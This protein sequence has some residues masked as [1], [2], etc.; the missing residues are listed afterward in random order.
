MCKTRQAK[1]NP[2]LI[3]VTITFISF[4]VS[5]V[6]V[7]E[8]FV[9][10]PLALSENV[11]TN[12]HI[13]THIDYS[14][15]SFWNNHLKDFLNYPGP[16]IIIN[17]FSNITG[18]SSYDLIY[19]PITA[20]LYIVMLLCFFKMFPMNFSYINS[21]LFSLASIYIISMWPHTW[22]L[23]YHSIGYL[24]HLLFL[25]LLIK[26]F[27]IN[28][29][30]KYITLL[31]LMHTTSLLSYY[32]TSIFNIIF[33]I[34]LASWALI[35]LR[36]KKIAGSML[37]FSALLFIMYVAYDYM[38]YN[39]IRYWRLEFASLLETLVSSVQR[40]LMGI[41]YSERLYAYGYPYERT[42]IDV[43]L[44]RIN[45]IFMTLFPITV[46]LI[47]FFVKETKIQ[48]LNR[49][50][51]CSLVFASLTL[52]AFESVPY[53]IFTGGLSFRYLSLFTPIITISLASFNF[54]NAHISGK[55]RKKL[56]IYSLIFFILI[57]AIAGIRLNMIRGIIEGM[58]AIK[59]ELVSL[60]EYVALASYAEAQNPF[61]SNFQVSAELR[62]ASI[63]IKV[64]QITG[65]EPFGN[66]IYQLYDSIV[67]ND[68]RKISESLKT[69]L[70]LILTYSDLL[71]PIYGS[72]WGNAVPPLEKQCMKIL[73]SE[74]SLVFNS[75]RI[76]AFYI[77]RT[78]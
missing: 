58:G 61:F 40:F 14:V 71:K 54:S 16:A 59:K 4:L 37:R 70:I 35:L 48:K 72:M 6:K 36:N 30:T 56:L 23:T 60:P 38:I 64:Y 10:S 63:K 44:S 33:T 68:L 22:N 66:K 20:V 5:Y 46:L 29:R 74:L 45:L 50:K 69:P 76:M 25:Y 42:L 47:T 24:S 3:I 13:P 26:S 31:L 18:V 7:I 2:I 11:G 39:V 52:A 55:R 34:A 57:A 51:I 28:S 15:D 1:I 78:W 75:G 27:L 53:S 41:P 32:S 49:L 12:G 65:F 19:L 8:Y 21:S 9:A 73:S 43:W 77:P 17:F 62:L 67:H